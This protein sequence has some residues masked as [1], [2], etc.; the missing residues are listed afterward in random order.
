MKKKLFRWIFYIVGLAVLAIGLTLNTKTGLGASAVI[1]VSFAVSEI[2]SLNLGNITFL[3]YTLF[4]ALQLMLHLRSARKSGEK[5]GKQLILD[6]LQLPLS[7]LFTRAMNLVSA[8]VPV[9]GEAYPDR[10]WGTFAGRFLVLLLAVVCTGVGAAMSLNMRLVPNATD[11]VVQA[12]AE[13]TG[14]STGFTKNWFDVLN[15][16]VA[17]VLGLIFTR[18]LLSIGLGTV[19]SALGIGRVIAL[20]N[21]LFRERLCRLTGVA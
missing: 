5:A 17:L 11:G 16:C 2:W 1:S 7:L 18:S 9:L 14:K 20:F 8:L 6:L 15:V 10:F 3:L 12:L 4:V 13:A 19:V 21:R